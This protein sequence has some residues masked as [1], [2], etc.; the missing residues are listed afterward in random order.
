MKIK[1]IVLIG[2][3]GSGKS[4]VSKRL[5]TELKRPFFSTDTWIE[6]RESSPIAKIFAEKGE[7]Y[8]RKLER[9]AVKEISLKEGL[10]IDCGGGIVLN[11]ANLAD[12][13]KTGILF[14]LKAS[15]EFLFKNIQKSKDRPLMNT[16]NP[17]VKIRELLETRK[18][19]YEEAQYIID[20]DYKTIDEITEA[21]LKVIIHE[22]I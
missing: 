7:G 9:E 3:M 6:Q 15:A 14:Y 21:I 2:F 12:L 13:K 16:E 17:F 18:P 4:F 20:A 19:Y 22:R 11:P 5:S 1:N 8:F 10:I